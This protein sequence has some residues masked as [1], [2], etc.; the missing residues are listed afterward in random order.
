MEATDGDGD[1]DDV[2]DNNSNH[3]DDHEVDGIGNGDIDD[4][5]PM[6][7]DRS[8]VRETVTVQNKRITLKLIVP[9]LLKFISS[10]N[11]HNPPC[12]VFAT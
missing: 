4:T 11:C 5:E 12:Y 10:T 2:D 9:S 8:L 6:T 7:E 1:G 3:D